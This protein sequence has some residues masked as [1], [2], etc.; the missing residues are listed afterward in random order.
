MAEHTILLP[1]IVPLVSGLALYLFPKRLTAWL[2]F[3]GVLLNLAAVIFIFGRQINYAFPWCGLG[4]EFALRLD[5]FSSFISLAAGFFGFLIMLY[6]LQFL[7]GRPLIRK[8]CFYILITLSFISGIILADNLGLLLFFWEGLLIT[9]F[10]MIALGHEGAFRTA[11]KAFIIVGLSDICLMG[12][13]I[14]TGYLAGTLSISKISLSSGA[15]TNIA[16]LLLLIGTLA[17]SGSM[18]FH[19]WIPDAATDAPLPFMAFLPGAIEKLVGIYFLT[20]LTLDMF[21]INHASW[22]SIMLMV[23]GALTIVF[24]VMMALIQK[25]YK[26][27]L[28]YH[29]ISQVG[30][31]VLGIGTCI[32]AGIV[33]GLFHMLNNALYKSGLFLTAGAVEKSAGTTDLTKLGGLRKAMPVTFA[34][35]LITALSISG[36]PPFNGF[37]SKELIYDA[38]LE[39][40]M[41]F[42]VLAVL[43]SFFT[44][45]SFLKLGHAAFF[46][47][48]NN[49]DIKE[50]K[51]LMLM[52]MITIAFVCILFGAFNFIPLRYLIQPAVADTLGS[53]D[54]SGLPHNFM[55]VATSLIVIALAIAHH[56]ILSRVKGGALHAADD[57]HYAPGISQIYSWAEK[58][59]FDPYVIGT[60]LSAIFARVLWVADRAIDWFYNRLCPGLVLGVSDGLRKMHTGYYVV[61]IVWSIIGI[62]FILL[63]AIH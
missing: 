39:R 38:A 29:A 24:A 57:I 44:A 30:Y 45:I 22:M 33:G 51:T 58:K 36:V 54:Y 31:M 10:A 8:F 23:I 12:G 50:A 62:A 52:P 4:L 27:L 37:F 11:A 18:P 48:S 2:A 17:K 47:P 25:D 28:S 26:R 42:Y 6:S 56:F 9:L 49:R 41:F 20:R 34:C 16:F 32:P 59:Y 7:R 60:R 46:G 19:T 43:G 1:I 55:I 61:Y 5:R 40:G 53:H 21:K 14:L 13:I 63:A 35:F 15:L 3:L